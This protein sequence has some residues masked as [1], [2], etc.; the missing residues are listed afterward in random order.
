MRAVLVYG[1]GAILLGV[2]GLAVGDFALQW[3]PVPAWVPAR[4]L[5]ARLVAAALLLAGI[6]TVTPRFATRGAAALGILYALWLVLLMIPRAV[7][8]PIGIGVW[9]GPCE[10]L[11]L[12]G[13]GIVA[14]SAIKPQLLRPGRI[15]FGLAPLV[16]GAAHFAYADFTASLIPRWIPWPLFWAYATGCFHFAAGLSILSGVQARLAATLLATMMAGFVL[17]LHVPRVANA[18]DSRLEW[19]MLGIATSLT[20]AAVIVAASYRRGR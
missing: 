20:G 4:A 13:G 10:I 9:N 2:I 8:Q 5:L 11:A 6:A 19:T 16:F 18:P 1:V 7:V 3:Q 12:T 17:L 15:A 14:A